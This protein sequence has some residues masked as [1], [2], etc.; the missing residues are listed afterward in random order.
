MFVFLQRVNPTQFAGDKKIDWYDDGLIKRIKEEVCTCGNPQQC[1][2]TK[3]KSCTDF[4]TLLA[5]CHTVMPEEKDGL[6]YAQLFQ[7]KLVALA[8]LDKPFGVFLPLSQ[9]ALGG[10]L[11]MSCQDSLCLYG[12][13]FYQHFFS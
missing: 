7:C 11:R 1:K 6:F 4:F 5:L 2:C 8:C 12:S 10:Q 13:M 9:A 3:D